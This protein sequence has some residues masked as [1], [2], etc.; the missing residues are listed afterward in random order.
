MT[1]SVIQKDLEYIWNKLDCSRDKLKNSRILITGFG[2]FLG[3]YFLKFLTNFHNELGIK[4]IICVDTFILGKK[5]WIV[6]LEAQFPNLLT[7]I[8]ASVASKDFKENV[9][10]NEVDYIIHAASIASPVFYRQHPLETIDANIW[11]LR[12]LL[13]KVVEENRNSMKGFLFFSSSEI[14]G[15]PTQDSIPTHEDYRGLV[16]CHGPRACYDESKRFGET[17]CWVYAQKYKL[18]ITIAR[19]FNNYGPGMSLADKRLPADLASKVLNKEDIVLYSDGTPTRTFCYIADAIIG[20]FKCLTYGSYDYF[21]IGNDDQELSVSELTSIYQLKAK[22]LFQTDIKVQF[23]QSLDNEYL[24][25]NPNR[26]CPDLA[27]ARNI[28]AY[29][30]EIIVDDGVERYLTFAKENTF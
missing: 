7:V 29:N 23:E 10:I 8:D 20:Y 25:D 18:P 15:D 3:F 13:D 9:P 6:A 27:K 17:I 1:N 24:T 11:G 30:P 28:L 22:L 21:N 16:S 2:G 12:A 4:E 26:R 14:Y 5:D 19:P